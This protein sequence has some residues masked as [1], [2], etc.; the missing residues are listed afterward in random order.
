[1]IKNSLT[2]AAIFIFSVFLVSSCNVETK[3]V[4]AEDYSRDGEYSKAETLFNSVLAKNPDEI[5]A[6][7]GLG[8]ISFINKDYSKAIANYKKA[9]EINASVGSKEMV[10]ILT[11]TDANIR[12][13]AAQAVASL[14]SG[15]DKVVD[16]IISRLHESNQYVKVDF[17][18]AIRRI[19]KPASFAAAEIIPYLSNDFSVVRKTALET[20]GALDIK[21]V[22]ESGAFQ[23]IVGLTKDGDVSVAETAVKI[24]A[25]YKTD[26]SAAVPDLILMYNDENPVLRE[27][28]RKAVAEIGKTNKEALPGLTGLLEG[29]Y[30]VN[31]RI[32]ALDSLAL[33]G[34]LSNVTIAD[35]IPLSVDSNN[36][37]RVVAISALSKIGR[38][39]EE[40]VPK[41]A[42]LLNYHNDAVVLRSIAELSEMG[43]AASPALPS[44]NKLR[45]NPSKAISSEARRAALKIS[46]AQK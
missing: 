9:I 21:D 12:Q 28:A 44:L 29:K 4:A 18:D 40:S 15:S 10:S 39:S 24:L 42:K 17:L 38:P 5:R 20:F 1:M 7:K 13:E 34:A 2:A 27:T 25:S 6:L 31:V 46:K 3:L 37:V 41:L 32:A 19:G 14:S 8:D 36:D 22:K 11:Y 35:I 43:K 26:S 33:M 45:K 23:K 16:A 30:P